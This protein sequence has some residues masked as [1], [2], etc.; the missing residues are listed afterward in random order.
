MRRVPKFS[1]RR[2]H[3]EG[4]RLCVHTENDSNVGTSVRLG[5][6]K[7]VRDGRRTIGALPNFAAVQRRMETAVERVLL[8]ADAL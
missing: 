7:S 8:R 5:Y 4:A 3:L 6:R 2:R 1:V